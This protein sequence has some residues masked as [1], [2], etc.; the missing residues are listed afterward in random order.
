VV[1]FVIWKPALLKQKLNTDIN[2]KSHILGK[3]IF[4]IYMRRQNKN[5]KCSTGD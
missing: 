1:F 5:M 2:K 4:L 3:N